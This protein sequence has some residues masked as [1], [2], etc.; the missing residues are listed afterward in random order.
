[1]YMFLFLWAQWSL[2]ILTNRSQ[3]KWAFCLSVFSVIAIISKW[4]V[5]GT[6]APFSAG[7]KEKMQRRFWGSR[8]QGRLRPVPRVR[9]SGL[10]ADTLPKQRHWSLWNCFFIGIKNKVPIIIAQLI[11][12]QILFFLI[13]P[14]TQ[15]EV[16]KC[17]LFCFALLQQ[18]LPKIQATHC[19]ISAK[20]SGMKWLR[21]L[22]LW[23]Q[24]FRDGNPG[25]ENWRNFPSTQAGVWQIV[26]LPEETVSSKG[27]CE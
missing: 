23:A 21:R 10:G 3:S 22:L 24:F 1:M 7:L 13:E 19:F 11:L 20:Q 16:S 26:R 25:P 2:K 4:G 14:M 12:L 15:R 6:V 5:K 27:G 17:F 9:L 18:Y 8:V